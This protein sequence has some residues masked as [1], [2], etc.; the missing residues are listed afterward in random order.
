MTVRQAE[1][2]YEI[3]KSTIS[4]RMNGRSTKQ[5]SA[6]KQRLFSKKEDEV[7]FQYIHQ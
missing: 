2:A 7:L 3:P 1:E 6:V 4:A 5:A